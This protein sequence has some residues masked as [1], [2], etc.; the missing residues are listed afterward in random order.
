MSPKKNQPPRHRTSRTR[1]AEFA[2]ILEATQVEEPKAPP[3]QP[4]PKVAEP[5]RPKTPYI[6]IVVCPL[7]DQY[8]NPAPF[9]LTFYGIPLSEFMVSPGGGDRIRLALERRKL[10]GYMA[11]LFTVYERRINL[12]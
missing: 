3:P 12:S 4:E 10:G 7:I 9:S 2:A 8:G 6:P 5:V 11:S 1:I